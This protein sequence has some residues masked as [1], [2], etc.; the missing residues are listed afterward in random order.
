MVKTGVER[1]IPWSLGRVT[2]ERWLCPKEKCEKNL[3]GV[4]S[5]PLESVFKRNRLKKYPP[6][7]PPLHSIIT[8]TNISSRSMGGARPPPPLFLDQTEA[9]RAGKTF[10]EIAPPLNLRVWMIP[11]PPLISRSGSGTEH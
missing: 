5:T 3:V 8:L 11:P 4:E 6:K 7:Y 1:L 9:R 2:E 10:L